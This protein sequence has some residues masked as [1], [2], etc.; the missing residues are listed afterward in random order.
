LAA[1]SRSAVIYVELPGAEHAFD[2]WPSVRTARVAEGIG[3]FLD[4]VLSEEAGARS[5]PVG[6]SA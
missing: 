3:R 4:M 1:V 6:T 5:K 2:L